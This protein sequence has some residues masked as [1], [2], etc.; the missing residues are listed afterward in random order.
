M[1]IDIKHC[2]DEFR[3]AD[4]AFMQYPLDFALA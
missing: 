2:F 1:D 3:R 4:V